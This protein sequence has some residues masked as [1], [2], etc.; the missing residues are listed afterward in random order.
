MLSAIKKIDHSA[1]R[2][3]AVLVLL[4]LQTTSL[5]LMMRITRT[6]EGPRYS[7]SSAVLIVEGIK[8][9]MCI[10]LISMQEGIVGMVKL[11]KKQVF[12]DFGTT[13]KLAV[14]SGLYAIQNNLLYYALSNLDAATYQ[15]LYQLKVLTT[16]IFSVLLLGKKLSCT[17]WV[18]LFFL[19]AGCA[20]VQLQI[21]TKKASTAKG[22][23]QNP[24]LGLVC[25]LI[26]C[27][28]SGFAGV[29]FE[30]MLKSS[31]QVS[32]WM[33]NIQLAFVWL[34]GRETVRGTRGLSSEPVHNGPNNLIARGSGT[35]EVN[36]TQY[37]SVLCGLPEGVRYRLARWLMGTTVAER[38]SRTGLAHHS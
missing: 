20:I 14:P 1:L 5:V 8:V 15:V 21:S 30:K 16:A 2:K 28:T 34:H 19:T 33:R 4:I 6:R 32:I 36:E 27:C 11:V 35:Q 3:W 13:V 9:I 26:S 31:Q 17:Q 24:A 37:L 10:G 29:Y 12:D 38:N 7:P 22:P 23:V 25:I 18:A